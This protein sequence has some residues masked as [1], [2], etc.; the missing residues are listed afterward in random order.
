MTT[1]LDRPH[2]ARRSLPPMTSSSTTTSPLP[3]SC[4]ASPSIA[5]AI[6]PV[7]LV[8]IASGPALTAAGIAA[9]AFLLTT[10]NFHDL[11]IGRVSA[12]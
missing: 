4:A 12:E 9:G 11:A 8:A 3:S 6:G 5:I 7:I 10:A 1:V 2:G